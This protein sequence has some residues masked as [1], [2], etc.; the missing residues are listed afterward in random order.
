MLISTKT[1]WSVDSETSHHIIR[2]CQQPLQLSA[3]FIQLLLSH[4]GKELV[5]P[6]LDLDHHQDLRVIILLL[7]AHLGTPKNFIKIRRVILQREKQRH[8]LVGG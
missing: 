5:D 2:I 3:I 6:H 7:V 8:N 4:N 1:E